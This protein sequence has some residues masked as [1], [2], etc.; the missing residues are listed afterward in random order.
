MENEERRCQYLQLIK[1][2][3]K[4]TSGASKV[5]KREGKEELD[6]SATCVETFLD[7]FHSNSGTNKTP[8]SKISIKHHNSTQCILF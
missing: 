3:E 6:T 1:S 2:K 4:G 8:S 5:L 7:D